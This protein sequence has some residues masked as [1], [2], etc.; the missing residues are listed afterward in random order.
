VTLDSEDGRPDR[1]NRNGRKELGR[2]REDGVLP[3]V[4]YYLPRIVTNWVN[5][6]PNRL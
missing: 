6:H 2:R 3:V 1:P 5:L 4:L